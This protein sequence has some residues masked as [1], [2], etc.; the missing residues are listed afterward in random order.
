MSERIRVKFTGKTADGFVEGEIDPADVRRVFDDIIRTAFFLLDAGYIHP[1]LGND[2]TLAMLETLKVLQ[3]GASPPPGVVVP[4]AP[5]GYWEAPPFPVPAEAIHWQHWHQKFKTL[6]EATLRLAD[7]VCH[8]N[9]G[10]LSWPELKESL[11]KAY[12]ATH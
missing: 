4:P 1:S 8:F 10:N 6:R 3:S 7:E 11:A 2:E 5:P 9:A 12:T